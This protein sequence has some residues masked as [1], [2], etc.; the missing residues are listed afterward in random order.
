MNVTRPRRKRSRASRNLPWIRVLALLVAGL[1]IYCLV[2][3]PSIADLNEETI[4]QIMEHISISYDAQKQITWYIPKSDAD[5]KG[6]WVYASLGVRAD[7][8]RRM[9]LNV[10]RLNGELWFTRWLRVVINGDSR[11]I[12]LD[13]MRHR[14]DGHSTASGIEETLLMDDQAVL[15]RAIANASQV[16]IMPMGEKK[17]FQKYDLLEED[18]KNFL[19]IVTLFDTATLPTA[20]ESDI[21]AAKGNQRN[22]TNPRLIEKSKKPPVYPEAARRRGI[23]GLVI[24]YAVIHKDG[25]V[26]DIRVARVPTVEI[27]FEE[28]AT[29]AVRKWKYEPALLDG[30]PI[31]VTFTIIVDFKMNR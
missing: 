11:D 23:V 19:R 24:L 14:I 27:G 22:F 21:Q 10:F 16:S 12:R 1:P 30:K 9:V 31:D 20:K 18:L 26:G 28:A 13:P 25:T 7:G 15:I 5:T 17:D 3:L 4:D 6:N 8:E 2:S 29:N